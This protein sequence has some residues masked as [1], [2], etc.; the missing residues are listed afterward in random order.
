MNA[1]SHNGNVQDGASGQSRGSL[2]AVA[3]ADT[4]ELSGADSATGAA[5]AWQ[6]MWLARSFRA[7]QKSSEWLWDGCKASGKAAEAWSSDA[8]INIE[9]LRAKEVGG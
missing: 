5:A 6:L 1:R 4:S 8:K 7:V 3:A 2:G 9:A